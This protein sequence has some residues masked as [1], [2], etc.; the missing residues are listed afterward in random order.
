[1]KKAFIKIMALAIISTLVLAVSGCKETKDGS[2]IHTV[3]FKISYTVDGEATSIDSTLTLYET[4]APDTTERVLSLINGGYYNDTVITLSKQ[5][6]YAVVGGFTEGYQAK[7]YDGESIRGEFT[8]NGLRSE[9]VVQAGA[10]VM[11]RDFDIDSGDAKYDTAKATFAIVLNNNGEFNANE[12]CVFGYIDSDSLETLKEALEDN[13]KNDKDYVHMRYAGN[14][15]NGVPS[16]ANGG[17]DYYVDKDGNYCKMVGGDIVEMEHA[18]EGDED[19][20]TV[21]VIKDSDNVQ[22]IYTLPAITFKVS[23]CVN[24]GCKR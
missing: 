3:D 2:V 9:L 1:M 16:Y 14:R 21:E 24:S 10:L 17:F 5:A 4:F 12:Y 22:D 18:Q 6:S 15:V 23:A 13:A 7:N 20:D 8:Q 19:Y 11:L